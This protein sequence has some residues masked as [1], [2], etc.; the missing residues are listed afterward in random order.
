[1]AH[2]FND[3]NVMPEHSVRIAAALKKRGIP[4]M[5]YYHQG[6]HGGP[7]PMALMNRW[8]TRYLYGVQN[9]IENDPRAWIVREGADRQQP[10]PYQDYPNPAAESVH[11]FL[12]AGG[13]THGMLMLTDPANEGVESLT[14]DVSID[15]QTLA[16]AQ[17]SG[18]RLLYVTPELKED[19][20][21]SGTSTITIRASADKPAVNLSIWMVSLPWTDSQRNPLGGIITRGW[22]D[23]QNHD[24]LR[25]SAPLVPGQFYDMTFD[26]QPDDQIVKAGQRIGL[27]I[28][29]SDR[30][31][32]LRPDPGTKLSVDLGG[33]SI[34]VPVVG[35][36]R[37]LAKA[38]GEDSL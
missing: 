13:A 28:F 4:V 17:E 37:A 10:T 16:R 12:E 25:E 36:K 5:E 23:L 11:L 30:D 6:G 26:L 22:A 24:S 18:H 1:M 3:W 38:L 9:D 29:S 19:V 7:P 2:G 31:F 27:M 34:T 21:F 32:T 14:D 35:G 20:H 33:T 8:F 15:G